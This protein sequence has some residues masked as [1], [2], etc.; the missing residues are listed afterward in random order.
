M[1]LGLNAGTGH[2]AALT[3]CRIVNNRNI[4][5]K[6]SRG[7]LVER[8]VAGGPE[9]VEEF[10]TQRQHQLSGFH[11]VFGDACAPAAGGTT[12]TPRLRYVWNAPVE[13]SPEWEMGSE[14][15]CPGIFVISNENPTVDSHW[16]KCTWLKEQMGSFL[17]SL[18]K[19]PRVEDVHT[20][21]AEILG[22]YDVP[23]ISL[24]ERLPTVFPEHQERFLQ[25]GPFAPWRREQQDFGTVSQR[26]LI[27]DARS[28]EMHYFH[29]STNLG[30]CARLKEP[31]RHGPWARIRVPW[32]RQAGQESGG[33]PTTPQLASRL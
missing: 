11:A 27:S 12:D 20:H 32:P 19:E 31:P 24:P 3:N 22:R 23:E 17:R 21:L 29:R 13:G 8:M 10:I 28:R 25:S 9:G 33:G 14:G 4:D 1:V 26:V 7:H 5:A 30:Y 2:F 6:M 16:P 15:L 18:P